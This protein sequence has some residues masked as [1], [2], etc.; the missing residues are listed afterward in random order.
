[1][2]GTNPQ[3]QAP[4]IWASR[5]GR[6]AAVV[7]N[8]LMPTPLPPSHR[9]AAVLDHFRRRAERMDHARRSLNALDL[10]TGD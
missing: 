2:I 7:P 8:N 1:M 3:P 4:A 9:L 5:V 6:V 10:A